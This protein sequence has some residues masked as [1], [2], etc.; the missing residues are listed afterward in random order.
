MTADD[1]M[2][3]KTALRK[4]TN[5][6]LVLEIALRNVTLTLN[7]LITECLNVEGK[8]TTPSMQILMRSRAALPSYC[9]QSFNHKDKQ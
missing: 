9:T 8:P 1:T 5:D 6:A 3:L 7:N 4:V 2:T